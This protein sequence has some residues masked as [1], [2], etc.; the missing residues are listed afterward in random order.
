MFCFSGPSQT[1][2]VCHCEDIVNGH[3]D[4]RM[5]DVIFAFFCTRT[6]AVQNIEITQK[7]PD[8]VLCPAAVLPYSLQ[9]QDRLYC[10]M[11]A[12][13]Y[14]VIQSLPAHD[15]QSTAKTYHIVPKTH[16]GR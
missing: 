1:N 15:N 11:P 13:R 3:P 16:A 2:T 7:I 14:E 5:D 10:A 6:L 12:I 8:A 9:P 4:L